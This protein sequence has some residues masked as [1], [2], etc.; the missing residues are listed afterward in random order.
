[1]LESVPYPWPYLGP[2]PP[3]RLALVVTGAQPAWIDR[4]V[5]APAVGDRIDAIASVVRAAGGTVFVVRHACSRTRH[6]LPP[7]VRTPEWVLLFDVSPRDVVVDAGGVD[8]F[9]GSA[10]DDELRLRGIDHLVLCGFA[11]EATV[12]S[13]LRSANDRGYEC[14]TLTDAV[15]PLD[16]DLG[17]HTLSSVTMSGGIFGAVAS[18]EYLLAQLPVLETT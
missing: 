11:A 17:R 12:D 3:H 13:T 7:R 16:R 8:G 10:L 15:A 2:V 18:S 1:M 4:S 6:P 14:L 5:D 9:H